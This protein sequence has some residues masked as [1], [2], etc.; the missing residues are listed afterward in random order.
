M[1]FHSSVCAVPRRDAAGCVE[2]LMRSQLHRAE[3]AYGRSELPASYDAVKTY[4]DTPGL[5]T[6][7]HR[8]TFMLRQVKV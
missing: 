6:I 1:P 7:K 2:T 5:T 3:R 8:Y 4:L